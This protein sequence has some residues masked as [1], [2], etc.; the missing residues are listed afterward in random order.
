MVKVLVVDD[1]LS[2]R[3]VVERALTSRRIETV[4]V[5]SGV[6]ALERIEREA[7]DLVVCDVVMPDRDGW[8]ICEFV[9]GHTLLGGTP[10][11]LMT[12]VVDDAVR[13]RAREVGAADILIKP[14]GADDL[15]RRLE[16]LLP[17]GG[18][19]EGGAPGPTAALP[20]DVDPLRVP[21]ANATA[22]PPDPG[23]LAAILAQ[24]TALDGVQWAVLA[25]REG[26]VLERAAPAGHDLE[27]VAALGA[28]V[29][30]S[31][32]TLGRELGR[33]A[34][35]GAMLEYETGLVVVHA[36]AATAT[37]VLGISE[38]AALGKMR[39]AVKKA[40]PELARAV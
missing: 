30:G 25:D 10:V 1:S 28:S 23:A 16:D 32:G 38:P 14:F 18:V 37:L 11:L 24:L 39:Y 35:L 17:G 4:T 13:A 19:P 3:K 6:E 29:A 2:V 8:A 12:G 5:A 34:L 20:G 33:G 21:A 7:P 22:D 9:K 15:L 27:M 36:V 26:F 40:L 31:S